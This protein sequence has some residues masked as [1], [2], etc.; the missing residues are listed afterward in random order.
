MD[1]LK[2]IG[3]NLYERRLWV[4][5]LARGTSTAGELS[6]I[7][8]V[9]RSRSYDILQSL[10]EKGFVIVQTGKPIRYVTVRPAEALDRAKTKLEEE[11]H[12]IEDRIEDLKGSPTMKEMD[13]L[14]SKGMKITTPEE[15][16]GAL[17]GRYSVS[18]QIGS[19]LKDASKSINI[20]TNE[21]GLDEL[22]SN[23]F[24]VLRDAKERGVNI[25]I[26]A[27]AAKTPDSAK[28]LNSVGEVRTISKK[29]L[30]ID[31]KFFIVDG[32]E[33]LMPLT[34]PKVV[35]D[36]QDI[37]I[38]SKSNYAASNLLNPIFDHLWTHGKSLK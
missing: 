33:M 31:G 30:A 23:H 37:A 9:P 29:D 4:A 15:M 36:T 32:K 6:E 13:E 19:M 11:V 26:A 24:D 17:K 25:K 34:D 7:A 35:H 8:N 5:L 12:S 20:V 1:A 27:N 2:G 14:F 38:W 18:Q 3:L 10:S 28:S 21:A 22:L 16:T